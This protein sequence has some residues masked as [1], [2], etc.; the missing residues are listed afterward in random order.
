MD[1][2]SI[3]SERARDGRPGETRRRLALSAAGTGVLAACGTLPG[4]SGGPS[5][6]QTKRP[7]TLEYWDWHGAEQ[8]AR[9]QPMV[10]AYQ[11]YAPYATLKWIG[12][13]SAEILNK[14]TVAVAGGTPPD[15]AYM[16]NQHQGFYGR[17]KLLVDQG[18]LGKKDRD[19]GYNLIDPRALSL[20]TYDG[21]QLGYPWT[22]TTA[23]VF[24][25]RDLFK[26]AGQATPDE[27]YKQGKW[28]WEAMTQA[29]VALTKRDGGQIQQLGVAHMSVWRLALQSNGSDFFDDPRRPRKARLDEPQAID[30]IAYT[31]D[32]AHKYQAG[33]R[34]PEATQL[35]GND[36]NAF[37]ANK[38]AMLV[39]HG[40]PG[41]YPEVAAA[42]SAVPYPKGPDAKGRF[43]TD[44][45]TEAAG[46]MRG[47]TSQD[48][49]WTFCRWYHK[50]WQR[51]TLANTTGREARVASRSDLQ[52]LSRK[53]L[54]APADVWF[55]LTTF[56]V[57]S[58]PVNPDWSKMNAEI[59]NPGLNPVW[60][61][62]RAPREAAVAVAKQ[63]NDFLAA[64]PQ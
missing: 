33:W 20:Y 55:E 56:G 30:A 61:G 54:P 57:L 7:V 40:V 11:K 8:V 3:T 12:V 43:I 50:D 15:I 32:L 51:E 59:L 16:D 47:S 39:R 58:R 10:D 41:Q 62:Q 14:V 4:Q 45:T 38:V 28:T 34:E 42:T 31:Q 26:A 19:F 36:N 37:H 52:E 9:Y 24:F 48:A 25:N 49:G 13:G 64:N 46:I 35:G 2:R 27:L 21:T 18:P 29:A 1:V 44:L 5:A 60:A 23:Q 63:L 17:Q 53:A 6:G 22:I